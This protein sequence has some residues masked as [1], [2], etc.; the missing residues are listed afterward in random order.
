MKSILRKYVQES[1][2]LFLTSN[3]T[4][5]GCESSIQREITTLAGANIT[6]HVASS[7]DDELEKDLKAKTKKKKSDSTVNSFGGGE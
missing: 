3:G 2:R 6:G 5:Q 7:S 1:L 4:L